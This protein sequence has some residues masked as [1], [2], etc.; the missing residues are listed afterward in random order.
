[1]PKQVTRNIYR[2]L[3][4]EEVGIIKEFPDEKNAKYHEEVEHD[5]VYLPLERSDLNRLLN[6]LAT[7]HNNQE[8]ITER[9]YNTIFGMTRVD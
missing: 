4:C 1:M 9:L 5:R 7:N 3:L 8:L 2:C 6:F